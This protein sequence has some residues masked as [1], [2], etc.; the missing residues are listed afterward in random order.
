MKRF[1]GSLAAVV[2]V[3]SLVGCA[4][5]LNPVDQY[6]GANRPLAE[7]GTLRWSEYYKGLYGIAATSNVPNKAP[8][9]GRANAMIE[10]AL[11]YED[12][13][14]S[15]DQFEHLR[16]QAQVAQVA[17]VETRTLEARAA[18][19]KLVNEE[20]VRRNQ[21]ADRAYEQAYKM[22]VQPKATS[23]STTSCNAGLGNQLNCT[24]TTR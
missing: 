4:T 11:A 15:K 19:I 9:M 23:T 10:A 16:R 14:I 22:I 5:T 18:A 24:T 12:Q 17:E 8:F 7:A 3:A 20:A 2:L 13:K 21:E 6:A 1:A